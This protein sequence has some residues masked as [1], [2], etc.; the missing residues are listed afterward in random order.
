ML[1]AERAQYLIDNPGGFDLRWSFESPL[2]KP[3][4]FTGERL[5]HQ[6]YPDGITPAEHNYV[7]VIWSLMGAR[8]ASY[9]DAL[10]AIAKDL[11]STL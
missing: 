11:R 2:T 1:T 3:P 6:L 8:D 4:F 7:M 5:P 10:T 9:F